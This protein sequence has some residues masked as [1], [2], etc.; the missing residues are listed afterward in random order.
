MNP[1]LVASGAEAD[2]TTVLLASP[3][4]W[5]AGV[6]MA[7]E[8]VE[9]ALEQ[10]GGS[11]VYVRR[12]IVH[13]RT[14]VEDLASR[15]VIFVD[16]LA[17]IPDDAHEATV[18]FSAHGV[19]PAVAT[20]AD[21]R[22]LRVIDATCPLVRKVH[23]EARR[24][25]EQGK[26]IVL[27]G[28]AG[29]EEAEGTMGIAPDSTVLV[30]TVEDVA[31][32]EL[33][34]DA[35]VA[36]LTQT[37]LAVDETTA[38]VHALRERFPTLAQPPSDDICYATTNRQQSAISVVSE[39]QVLLVIGSAN[40]SNSQRLVELARRHDTP[41]YRIDGPTDLEPAWL[42]GVTTVGITAGASTPPDLVTQ[43]V[44]AL[45]ER[46]PV[47]VIER[48]TTTEN[49]RFTLPRPRPARKGGRS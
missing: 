37:T 12:Q 6:R 28:H 25:S 44:A 4:S 23:A 45:R 27:I 16:E 32:L 1:E 7:I 40:S 5:C 17:S 31:G 39:A 43:V 3:R 49:M 33:A 48:E 41:A 8:T 26:T 14:V 29:H 11:P 21:R 35:E 15:G 10:A 38:V 47:R 30:E 46:G 24:F 42:R 13:N 2:E 34:A 36:V 18:V 9:R 19:S 20:E 22:G